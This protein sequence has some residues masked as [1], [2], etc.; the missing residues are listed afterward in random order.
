MANSTAEVRAKLVVNGRINGQELEATGFSYGVPGSG[1]ARA[2]IDMLT[3][4]P[5]GFQIPALAYIL[6]TGTPLM[7]LA[8]H[9]AVNPFRES[10]GIY[11]AVRTLEIDTENHFSTSYSL[12]EVGGELESLFTITGSANLPPLVAIKP[13]VETWTPK[14]QGKIAGS[15]V[16]SWLTEKGNLVTGFAKTNYSFSDKLGLPDVQFRAITIEFQSDGKRLQQSEK[17]VIFAPAALLKI[18]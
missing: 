4:V 14:G 12:R 3:A 6:L 16:M 9:G 5:A 8:A 10:R 15:F 1:T 2:D 7:S 18:G 13:T 17:I 11:D